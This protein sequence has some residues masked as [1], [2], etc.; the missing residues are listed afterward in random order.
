MMLRATGTPA[1][2]WS[3]CRN[4]DRVLAVP[5]EH[6][7]VPHYRSIEIELAPL[8]EHV[9]ENGDEGLA[10]REDQEQVVRAASERLVEN[11]LP[12]ADRT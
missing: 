3:N 7:P 6:G 5:A 8:G 1:R 10:C 11:D 4:R 9:D 12:V 2:C